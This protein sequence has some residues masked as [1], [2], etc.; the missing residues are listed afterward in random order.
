MAG[1]FVYPKLVDTNFEYPFKDNSTPFQYAYEK[2]GHTEFANKHMY[3]IMGH[4]G[5][6]DSFD[7]FMEGKFGLTKTMPNRLKGFGYDLDEVMLLKDSPFI[8]DVGGGRG[9]MLLQLQDEYP[10]LTPKNLVLQEF[11]SD[12]K[13]NSAV[14]T[15]VWN[16]KDGTP[17]PVVGAQVYSLMQ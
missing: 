16:F 13:P 15:M 5:R 1:A 6:M 12:G 9:Q 14:T 10:H 4:Q 8:V 3:E 2:M 11:S 17:Q 7:F